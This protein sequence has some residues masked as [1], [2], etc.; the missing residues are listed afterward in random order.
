MLAVKKNDTIKP[1]TRFFASQILMF[2]KLS[3]KSFV[4]DL[5]E[6]FMF[7]NQKPTEIY[8]KYNIDFVYVYHLLTDTDSTS[9]RLV[10][11]QRKKQG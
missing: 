1:L 11:L 5:V 9:I 4:Y 2:A 3:L 10:I 6:T 8:K 7:P